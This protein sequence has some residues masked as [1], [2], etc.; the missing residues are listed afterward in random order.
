MHQ[1]TVDNKLKKVF[2]KS[3][4][5]HFGGFFFLAA[6]HIMMFE[7]LWRACNEKGLNGASIPQVDCISL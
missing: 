4:F 7:W 1:V 2:L 5:H 3:S 6:V